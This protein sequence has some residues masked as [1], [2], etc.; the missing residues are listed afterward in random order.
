MTQ[1]T[2]AQTVQTGR[3]QDMNIDPV[4]GP[5]G[6]KCLRHGSTGSAKTRDFMRQLAR[7][8]AEFCE[9]CRDA[10]SQ[11]TE[12]MGSA[13]LNEMDELHPGWDEPMPSVEPDNAAVERLRE[14]S[15][16]LADPEP[17]DSDVD[18]TVERLFTES[19]SLEEVNQD[20]PEMVAVTV[21]GTFLGNGSNV[22]H[23]AV[24]IS[25]LYMKSKCGSTLLMGESVDP[26]DERLC[27]ACA[28]TG[29]LLPADALAPQTRKARVVHAKPLKAKVTHAEPPASLPEP[30]SAPGPAM[31]LVDV[32][33]GSVCA[34][35]CQTIE[36]YAWKSF[37]G[38]K[39]FHRVCP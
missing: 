7:N 26:A 10:G 28:G 29:T 17:D 14:L 1:P 34:A 4:Q 36:P 8:P 35:C 15:S 30:A 33:L 39:V 27:P 31:T 5:W 18:A 32:P 13:D 11:E 2:T 16:T 23:H 21:L 20:V 38:G 3:C 24:T 25:S 9:D 12:L 22:A 37:R 19:I 6:V